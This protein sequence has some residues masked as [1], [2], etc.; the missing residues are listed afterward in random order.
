MIFYYTIENWKEVQISYLD[1]NWSAYIVPHQLTN[2]Y[3]PQQKS[4]QYI[5]QVEGN[6][7][8]VE[9]PHLNL[10]ENKEMFLF[11]N[12]EPIEDSDNVSNIDSSNHQ[13]SL[14]SGESKRSLKDTIQCSVAMLLN[15]YCSQNELD[16][17]I[18]CNKI[19][20]DASNKNNDIEKFT[21][22]LIQNI[23]EKISQRGSRKSGSRKNS[24][25]SI[26]KC[27]KD[28]SGIKKKKL[29]FTSNEFKTCQTYDNEK[30]RKYVLDKKVK[31]LSPISNKLH[32]DHI[33]DPLKER[34]KINREI[35]D[36]K[37][38]WKYNYKI[39]IK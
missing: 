34:N 3:D 17:I 25:A 10:R 23:N 31:N 14:I 28:I 1:N 7:R 39:K 13:Y 19:I 37:M 2:F 4:A 22:N 38:F 11:D 24:Q 20:K 18:T 27:E 5:N 8:I 12:S 26:K 36:L 30:M 6:N 32:E 16:N 35:L 9:I 29:N 15:K 21:E 33:I